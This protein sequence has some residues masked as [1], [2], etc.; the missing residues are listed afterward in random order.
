ME[1]REAAALARTSVS[2]ASVA[3]LT[4]YPR[5]ASDR[6]HLTNVTVSACD[7]GSVVVLLRA[8]SLAAQHLLQRPFATVR[9]APPGCERVTLHGGA[10]RLPGKDDSGRL[11]FRVEAGAVRIGE[12]GETTVETTAYGSTGPD[13]LGREAGAVLAHLR[14]PCHAEQLAACLRAHGHDAEFAEATRLDRHG[15]TVLAVG[16]DGVSHVHL[17]FPEPVSR[18]EE[19]PPGLSVVLRCRGRCATAPPVEDDPGRSAEAPRREGD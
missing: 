2:C 18:L 5:S 13:P 4:T 14:L 12:R 1:P 11:A 16:Q 19:L 10:Q 7:D 9:V 15:I 6:P 8:G 17:P 3:A